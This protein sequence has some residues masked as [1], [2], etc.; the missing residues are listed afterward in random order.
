MV[1]ENIELFEELEIEESILEDKGPTKKDILKMETV[2][3]DIL[4]P[5]E[6]DD[7]AD[8]SELSDFDKKALKRIS[9]FID[10]CRETNKISS[11]EYVIVKRDEEIKELDESD[12]SSFGSL[13]SINFD[14]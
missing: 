3:S 12:F 8:I 1:K 2:Y 11:K 7:L 4:N 10:E 5:T 9:K 6:T 13:R 14:D